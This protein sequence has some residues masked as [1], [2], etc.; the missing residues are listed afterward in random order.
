[1]ESQSTKM[2]IVIMDIIL[3]TMTPEEK[4]KVLII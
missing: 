1:M 3:V 2:L 4:K